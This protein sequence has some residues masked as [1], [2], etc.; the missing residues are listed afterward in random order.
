VCP[1]GWRRALSPAGPIPLLAPRQ[2][3]PID[4]GN[5][6]SMWRT[7][8][9]VTWPRTCRP[10]VAFH[11]L[12]IECKHIRRLESPFCRHY[13]LMLL[14]R[15]GRDFVPSGVCGLRSRGCLQRTGGTKRADQNCQRFS[16]ADLQ[17][18][19]PPCSGAASTQSENQQGS[20]RSPCTARPQL[21]MVT[22]HVS[23]HKTKGL[24][25]R[26]KPVIAGMKGRDGG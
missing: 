18:G 15:R 10:S 8:M 1:R 24:N 13:I 3:G 26:G 19:C 23:C 16:H 12:R 22:Q 20:D 7:Q 6:P 25:Q 5:Q 14:C 17:N 11:L 21:M 4:G 2:A 9:R